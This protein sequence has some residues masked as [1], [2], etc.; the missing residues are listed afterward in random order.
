MCGAQGSCG[1]LGR[2]GQESKGRPLGGV[3]RDGVHGPKKAT[4]AEVMGPW[5]LQVYFEKTMVKLERPENGGTKN[6]I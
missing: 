1:E 4:G 3:G 5:S 2:R 6:P